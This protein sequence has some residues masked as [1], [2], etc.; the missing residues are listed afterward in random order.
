MDGGVSI[1]AFAETTG[2]ELPDG[3]YETVAGHVISVLGRIPEPGEQVAVTGGTLEV[4][5][6]VGNRITRLTVHRD[7]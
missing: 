7:G 1:E 2:I 3:A 6:V 4:T 5:E